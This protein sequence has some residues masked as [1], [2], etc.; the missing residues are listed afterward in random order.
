[1]E[2]NYNVIQVDHDL[3]DV[4]GGTLCDLLGINDGLLRD[5]I[6]GGG[7]LEASPDR[8][9][10]YWYH[11]DGKEWIQTTISRNYRHQV[12]SAV[13]DITGNGKMDYVFGEWV[14]EGNKINSGRPGGNIYWAEQPTDPFHN[15]WNIHKIGE[16]CMNAH[17]V[18]V[19]A[20][21]SEDSSDVVVRNK[22]GKLSWFSKPSSDPT[23]LWE[24]YV[25]AERQEGDGTSL[26]DITGNGGMDIIVNSGFYENADGKGTSWKF[27]SFGIEDLNFDAETRVAT[28]IL[29]DGS[30]SVVITE[31]ELNAKAR[32]LIL[33]SKDNGQ[34]WSR[35]ILIDKDRDFRAM[36]TLHLYDINGDGKLDIFTVEMENSKTDGIHS[37]PRW[38]VFL[39]KGDL[40]FEERVILDEN[41]GGHQANLG[42]IRESGTV[43]F[44]GKAWHPNKV[45]G[46]DGKNHIIHILGSRFSPPILDLSLTK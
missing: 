4:G 2:R 29:E 17:D 44:I 12:G 27:H 25:I 3:F 5:F 34:T 1:M 26:Y 35:N 41:L 8:G 46:N 7:L 37:K 14:A 39:N 40:Q 31:S 13:V 43:D 45:N 22:D 6:I 15:E 42:P 30:V 28:G 10:I 33:T 23:K 11:W 38:F 24:E 18:V 21:S 19:G 16:G 9:F 32:M 36:H 20:I